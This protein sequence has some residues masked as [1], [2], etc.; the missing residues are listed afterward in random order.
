MEFRLLGPVEAWMAGRPRYVGGVRERRALATLLLSANRTVG[1]DQLVDVLWG[2]DP[3]TTAAAQIRNTMA[4]LRRNLSA[5]DL[6]LADPPLR[7][8]GNGF[9]FRVGTE[10][11]DLL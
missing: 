5:A 4:T 11:L 10:E 2:D 6:A 9:V 7:R 8:S 1:V 3:P